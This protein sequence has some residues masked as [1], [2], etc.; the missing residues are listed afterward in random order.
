MRCIII[1][2]EPLAL[3]LLADNIK[4]VPRLQLVASCRSAAQAMQVL[5]AEPVDLVFCDIQMPGISGLQFVKSLAQKPM[6]IFITAYHEFAVDGFELDVVDY[7]L[8]PVPLE[9]FL[10]ACNKALHLHDIENKPAAIAPEPSRDH[11]FVY[12]DYNLIRIN[13]GEITYIEG[14][15]DYVKLHRNGIAKPVLSRITI[16]ALEEQLP[17]HQFFRT[18]KSY[19][20]NLGYVQSVRK[21]RIKLEDAEVPYTD[22]YREVI[23]RMTGKTI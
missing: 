6:V 4:Q 20:V 13:H 14:L 1:D 9:R 22:N 2:D 18:H 10:K 16:K 3:E 17:A 8:K 23:S 7:L 21:G 12:A 5:H 11:L 19:I 15:K